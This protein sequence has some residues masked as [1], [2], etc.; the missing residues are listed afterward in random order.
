MFNE[1]CLSRT[2]TFQKNSYLFQQKP[3]KIDEKYFLFHLTSSF[4]S[5]DI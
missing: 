5:Q 3:F 1:E 4:R 2:L